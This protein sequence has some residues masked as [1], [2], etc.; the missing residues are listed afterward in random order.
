[1]DLQYF[2]YIISDDSK[3][4]MPY[5]E[6]NLTIFEATN[7]IRQTGKDRLQQRKKKVLISIGVTDIKQNRSLSDMKREFTHLFLLCDEY[8][9]KP[10]ITTILC[11]ESPQLKQRADIFNRFLI[12]SFENVV[13]MRSVLTVGLPEVMSS[14]N[15]T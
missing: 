1:M 12:E 15:K 13:D 4:R 2:C 3:P 14:L 5:C 11:F 8:G 9:L 6:H 7:R 10:L